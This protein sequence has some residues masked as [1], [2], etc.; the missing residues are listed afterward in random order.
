MPPQFSRGRIHGFTLVELLV[1]L[2]VMALMAILG[3]RG[4]DGLSR[5]QAAAQ[6]R[7]DEVLT[8]QA[9]LGQWNADLA[10]MQ[11]LDQTQALDW[12]GRV[13]RITRRSSV[14][15][16]LGPRVVA[17]TRRGSNGGHGLWLRW[18]SDPLTARGAWQ[19]AWARAA[20]WAQNPG[21]A[22][23][24]GEVSLFALDG[25]QLFYFRGNAWTNPMSSAGTPSP[26]ATLP[27]GVRLVLD[28]PGGQAL[29]G[30]IT[31]DWVRPT[32]SPAEPQS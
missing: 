9:A 26:T 5:A 17:W 14:P 4:L 30:R 19:E 7:S 25:W 27:D 24:R 15:G 21:E 23:R 6:T 22:E 13:L 28:L 29:A 16:D 11:Q 2:G 18:Q 10:A 31:S 8:V 1:A 3:W 12:D 32:L 20:L